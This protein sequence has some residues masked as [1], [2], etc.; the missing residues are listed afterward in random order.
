L[1]GEQ[2]N[3]KRKKAARARKHEDQVMVVAEWKSNESA[4]RAHNDEGWKSHQ[5]H[6]KPSV[7]SQNT[8]ESGVYSRDQTQDQCKE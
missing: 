8:M 7:T 2:A 3:R 1:I 6:G 5:R 4:R